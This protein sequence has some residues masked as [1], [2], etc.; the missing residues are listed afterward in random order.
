MKA[1]SLQQTLSSQV[2]IDADVFIP[3]NMDHSN[4][5]TYQGEMLHLDMEIIKEDLFG[6]DA[7]VTETRQ[8]TKESRFPDED[9]VLWES[10]DGSYLAGKGDMISFS[11]SKVPNVEQYLCLEPDA[12]E[13]NGDAFLSGKNLSFATEQ[14]SFTKLRELLDKLGVSISDDYL[15]YTIDH[16][17]LIKEAD[18][19]RSKLVENARETEARNEDGTAIT[20]DDILAHLSEPNYT[21]EDD[22]YYFKLFASADGYPVT[23]IE[24][25]IFSNGGWTPGSIANAI[26]S[27]DGVVQ[28]YLYGIYES[29]E[30]I[31][32]GPG[33]SLN[34]AVAALDEK[35]NSIILDGEYMVQEI[36]FEYVPISHGDVLSVELTPAW[37]FLIKHSLKFAGKMDNQVYTVDQYEYIMLNAL[38][39]EE[40]LRDVGGV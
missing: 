37:R 12:F 17:T 35:Y 14:E 22:C 29:S 8:E 36:A 28:L 19:Y 23:R 30:T 31:N 20:E 26:V 25:G 33:L 5:K 16:D 18:I 21:E 11:S 6:A 39:G 38:T 3:A 40:I 1:D 24:N 32:Q 4:L 13:Y 15:C 9:Y 10:A 27:Q 7:E 2:K 34:D